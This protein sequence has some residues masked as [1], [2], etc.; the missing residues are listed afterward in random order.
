MHKIRMCHMENLAW[1]TY[2]D[3]SMVFPDHKTSGT[4][5]WRSYEEEQYLH[6]KLCWMTWAFREISVDINLVF[7]HN[8]LSWTAHNQYQSINNVA[9]IE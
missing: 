8:L 4:C 3:S 2:V 1:Q 5:S 6:I 7:H 9:S